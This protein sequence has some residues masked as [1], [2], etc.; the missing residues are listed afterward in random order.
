[1]SNELIQS[2]V[3][4]VA[5]QDIKDSKIDITQILGDSSQYNDWLD[6][7]NTQEEFFAL[8]PE[9]DTE[10]RLKISD[11][12]N[13][14]KE[15]IK[16]LKK[17]VLTLAETFERIEIN[18]E[19]LK[20][21]KELF[22]KGEIPEA[23]AVLESELEQMQDEQTRLLQK[24][25]D[26]EENIEA[27]LRNNAEE[28]MLLALLAVTDYENPNRF[29][30]VYDY[31]ERSIESFETKE[32]LFQYASMLLMTNH[33]AR[34]DKYYT[35]YLDK[36]GDK[37]DDGEKINI[38]INLGLLYFQQNDY[39]KAETSL[40]QARELL[41]REGAD[42]L[43][44]QKENLAK[45]NLN[46]ALVHQFQRKFEV[47]KKEYADALETLRELSA[48]DLRTHAPALAAVQSNLG[49]L[50]IQERDYKKAREF[51]LGSIETMEELREK[52]DVVL[53]LALINSSIN[54]S[55]LNLEENF[56]DDAKNG[57]HQTLTLIDSVI[58]ENPP[59]YLPGK[60]RILN[61]LGNVAE[62]EENLIETLMFYREALSIVTE[63]EKDDP[64]T[65]LQL[66]VII[67]TNL[68]GVYSKNQIKREES[69]EYVRQALTR[70]L[71]IMDSVPDLVEFYLKNLKILKEWGFTG[72]DIDNVF[73]EIKNPQ[74][75]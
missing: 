22:D 66:Y 11:K 23:R 67:I 14:L 69:I 55:Y 47:A 16:Q 73:A 38:H 49:L 44:N 6:Q 8:I 34:A 7:L 41:T 40:D 75:E 1:M 31:F 19:R 59:M 25:K 57:S 24:K 36:F 33:I 68:A 58:D 39:P 2:G 46:L 42:K 32:N 26:Y 21:A 50:S 53:P 65:H 3:G 64:E 28:F 72:K 56:L 30:N 12:I 15:K 10:K 9:N 5:L 45:A 74:P 4:G 60:A 62:K 20:R 54:L 48:K 27:K 61:I 70:L 29:T 35:R 17:D 13:E 63:L 51:L 43:A 71:P 52:H 37:L 18:T